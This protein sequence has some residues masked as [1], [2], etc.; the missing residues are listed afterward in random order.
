M[1]VT[2][3]T[4]WSISS[5]ASSLERRYFSITRITWTH[6]ERCCVFAG[7]ADYGDVKSGDT[8]VGD[9]GSGISKVQ[10]LGK[11]FHKDVGRYRFFPA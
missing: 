6:I 3:Y 11:A 10:P 8:P 4:R 5:P 9:S 7:L 1:V 2:K